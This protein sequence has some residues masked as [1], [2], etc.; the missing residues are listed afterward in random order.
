MS[1]P[2]GDIAWRCLCGTSVSAR[3]QGPRIMSLDPSDLQA[4]DGGKAPQVAH[5]TGLPGSGRVRLLAAK[6]AKGRAVDGESRIEQG[7]RAVR[8]LMPIAQRRQ[9]RIGQG[10]R[11]HVGARLDEFLEI[12]LILTLTELASCG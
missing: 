2:R 3:S 9:T 7:A 11:T 12:A 10:V 4:D 1:Q 8:P 5:L 6:N